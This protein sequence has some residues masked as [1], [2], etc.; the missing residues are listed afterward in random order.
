MTYSAT[1]FAKKANVSEE[2]IRALLRPLLVRALARS[3][4]TLTPS[5]RASVR[6]TYV[7]P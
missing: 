3:L 1:E 6:P 4:P 7:P 2:R 5:R